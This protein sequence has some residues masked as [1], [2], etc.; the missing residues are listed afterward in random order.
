VQDPGSV[1]GT[2]VNGETIEGRRRLESGD[3]I[4]F[5]LLEFRVEILRGE[6]SPS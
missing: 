5:G 3:R 6:G 4:S 2:V 1:N